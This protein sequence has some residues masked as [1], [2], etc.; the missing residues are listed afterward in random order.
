MRFRGRVELE[1]ARAA[2][3]LPLQAVFIGP[4]G[5]MV[6]RRTR[7]GYETVPVELGRRDDEW[8]EVLSGVEEGDSVSLSDLAGIGA[9]DT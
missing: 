1:R 9:R 4:A 5:P 6:Y 2:L 3:L 7:V 8:I